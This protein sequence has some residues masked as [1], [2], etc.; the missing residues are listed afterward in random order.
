[1]DGGQVSAENS[2]LPSSYITSLSLMV[3]AT[4]PVP[5]H[6]LPTGRVCR[7]AGKWGVLWPAVGFGGLFTAKIQEQWLPKAVPAMQ[8]ITAHREPI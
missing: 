4:C 3:W 7:E 8:S 2:S 5:M 1:M 6:A